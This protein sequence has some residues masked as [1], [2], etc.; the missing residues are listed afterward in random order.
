M[1]HTWPRGFSWEEVNMLTQSPLDRRRMTNSFAMTMCRQCQEKVMHLEGYSLKFIS[2]CWASTWQLPG[3]LKHVAL[4][5]EINSHAPQLQCCSFRH[6]AHIQEYLDAS[7]NNSK[8]ACL[9][10]QCARDCADKCGNTGPAP[11]VT[12]NSDKRQTEAN[13]GKMW[14]NKKDTGRN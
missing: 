2:I 11:Q 6:K 8:G 3:R 9:T 13:W 4:L 1:G 12:T 5:P 10:D 14:T 7:R